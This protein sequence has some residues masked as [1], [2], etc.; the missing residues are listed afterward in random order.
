[1]HERVG[2]V[3]V[4]MHVWKSEENLVEFFP[5]NLYI[6]SRAQ[7]RASSLSW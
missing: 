5:L 2:W 1:M 7:T 6:R 3:R 4:R